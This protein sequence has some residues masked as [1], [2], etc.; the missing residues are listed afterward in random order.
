MSKSL[1]QKARRA[2][3]KAGMMITKSR[4]GLSIDNQGGFMIINPQ[5]NTVIAGSK[6]ELSPDD[7]IAFCNT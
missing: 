4:C 2:A 5:N 1:E 7:V 6:F 3:R